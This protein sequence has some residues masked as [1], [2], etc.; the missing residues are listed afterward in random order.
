MSIPKGARN[1]DDAWDFIRW[2]C[3]TEEGTTIVGRE[4]ELFPGMRHSPYFHEARKKDHYGEYVAI[5]EASRHQRPVMPVQA[6]YM[7]EMQRA[8]EASIF[9]RKTPAQALADARRNTQAELDLA[10]AG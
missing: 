10:L 9:G 1:P 2:L 8:V 4:A 7:R 6:Y 5:L 3:H